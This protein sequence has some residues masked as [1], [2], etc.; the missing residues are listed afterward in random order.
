MDRS[1]VEICEKELSFEHEDCARFEVGYEQ[2][3]PKTLVTAILDDHCGADSTM[4]PLAP[5]ENPGRVYG[6]FNI[7]EEQWKQDEGLC[8]EVYRKY[9][10][11]D[12]DLNFIPLIFFVDGT[13]LGW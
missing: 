11:D 5:E 9:I 4:T 10:P 2:I 6:D 7:G 3:D 8:G 13:Q 1:E 12:F